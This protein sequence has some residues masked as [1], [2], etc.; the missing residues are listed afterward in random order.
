MV[1]IRKNKREESLQK[2]RREG[3]QSQQFPTSIHSSAVEKK[4]LP[5]YFSV[6]IRFDTDMVTL[7]YFQLI[8][9]KCFTLLFW[10]GLGL[11]FEDVYPIYLC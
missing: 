10:L 6:L 1:E 2:K 9:L 11:E 7:L 5:L 4:V 3:M 8:N